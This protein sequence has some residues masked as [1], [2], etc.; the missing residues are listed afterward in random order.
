MC[1][2]GLLA[3]GCVVTGFFD[4]DSLDASSTSPSTYADCVHI[5]FCL[6]SWS[7]ESEGYAKHIIWANLIRHFQLSRR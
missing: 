4:E 5:T 3:F 1:T 2:V 7:T 6:A